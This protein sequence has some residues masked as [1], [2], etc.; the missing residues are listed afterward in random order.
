MTPRFLHTIILVLLTISL[1]TAQEKVQVVRGNIVDQISHI[2]LPF[3]NVILS[4]TLFA[5]TDDNGVF[6]FTEVPIGEYAV[7]IS[8]IGYEDIFIRNIVVNSGKETVLQLKMLESTQQLE[9]V[10][11]SAS[12]DRTKPLNEMSILSTRMVGVEETN[13]YAS[14]FNDPA[15]MANSFAGV[16]QTDAGN[17][18][19][20]IRGNAPNGLLWR[21]EGIEIPNPNHFSFVGT[22]GGGVSIL[23]GQL[24]A[25]SDFSTGA[26]AAEYGNALS[27]V[28]D[29]KLRKGNNENREHTFQVGVLGIDAAIEGPFTKGGKNSYL[30]N[31]RYSTLGIISRLIDLEG[32]VTTFQDLSY[33][34]SFKN[35]KYGD[36]TFFGLNGL[37]KQ[38]GFDTTFSYDLD[39]I[40]N[41]LVNGMTHSKTISSNTFLKSVV[42]YAHTN[43]KL[44]VIKDED[45]AFNA[46]QEDHISKRLSF[47]TKL[48]HKM[49]PSTSLKAGLIHN[50]L[51]YDEFKKERDRYADPEQILYSREGNTSTSQAYA[52][53]LNRHSS[54]F[55]TSVGMHFLFNW[56]NDTWIMEPRLAA[57]FATT[58]NQY[59]S[60]G[61]GLHSQVL[62]LGTYFYEEEK[63]D[64]LTQPNI[65]LTMSKAHHVVL[66]YNYKASSFLNFKIETYYQHLFD[67]PQG[68]DTDENESLL[69]IEWGTI[70]APM[71]NEGSGRNYGVEFTIEQ[72]L[73]KG[74]YFTATS[75]LY[76]SEFKGSNNQWF[77]TRYNGGFTSSVTGGK[78]FVLSHKKNRKMGIHFKSIYTGG[79]RQSPIDL[80]ASIIQDKTV[81]DNTQPYS[82]QLPNYFRFDLKLSFKRNYKNVTTSL[83]FDIQNITNRQNVGYDSYNPNTQE[84]ERFNQV[85]LLPVI[86]YKIE[87]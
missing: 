40:S 47:S 22:A 41:T 86:S 46:F 69:N 34:L 75:S 3:A 14:A 26:F 18:H 77:P 66:G 29:I 31:Y 54:R 24:L 25:N 2:P 58:T 13:K 12:A 55:T 21:M 32:F 16:V 84:I 49:S 81:Y 83:V 43:N 39:F 48:Q 61:Y 30:V 72:M 35:K 57:K 79:L 50:L 6:K 8:Y 20:A 68:L 4:D 82:I 15:R 78:E 1:L 23:S 27:G 52:Q 70:D 11:V 67:I 87:F 38:T 45:I 42:V 10:V 37:S 44:K 5:V 76:N 63:G 64:I 71:V 53:I 36:I 51:W 74:Y 9:E 62:P 33:N 56:L 60:L 80:N 17:N 7:K 59:L 73:N 85:G 28:F 65:D 19:I